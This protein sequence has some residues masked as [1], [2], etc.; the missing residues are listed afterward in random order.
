MNL[1]LAWDKFLFKCILVRGCL[2][3]I[4]WGFPK[5]KVNKDEDGKDCAVREV[6]CCTIFSPKYFELCEVESKISWFFH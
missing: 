1:N 5:G 3:R 2:K 6:S 4:S